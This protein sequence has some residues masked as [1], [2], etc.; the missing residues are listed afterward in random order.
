MSAPTKRCNQC[1]RMLERE[2]FI[3]ADG[4]ERAKNCNECRAK[5][6]AWPKKTAAEKLDSMPKRE[7]PARPRVIFQRVSGNIKT[8]PIPVTITEG[9]TCP[10]ACMFYDAGCYASY[11]NLGASWRNMKRAISWEAFLEK[12][13]ALPAGTLWRHNEAGDLPGDG[14]CL[15]VDALFELAI[16]NGPHPT[17]APGARGFT[18][19]HKPLTSLDSR[20]A[21]YRA[22]AL[23]F[24]INRSADSLEEARYFL[25]LVPSTPVVV[26][27]PVDEPLPNDFPFKLVECPA[28]THNMTCEEC[29]LCAQPHRKS[30]IV[31]RAHGQA[32]GLVRELVR[33]KRE[34][35]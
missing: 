20:E 19:T 26:T 6:G 22:T 13:R 18:Y 7:R 23:G 15:D 27:L 29:Q 28:Q 31:F 5:Y 30:I 10:P 8:G 16:A 14:D 12:V 17:R 2:A 1:W 4:K 3:G 33:R 25:R 32:A 24:T 34:A 9:R 11:G 21:V 35:A